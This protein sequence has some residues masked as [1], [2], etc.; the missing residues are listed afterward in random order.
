MEDLKAVLGHGKL[1]SEG[2]GAILPSK[3]AQAPPIML[4]DQ[5]C[6]QIPAQDKNGL[7]LSVF[8]RQNL[9]ESVFDLRILAHSYVADR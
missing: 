3:L 8:N 5:V 4:K 2:I 1:L 7:S 6:C 9:L